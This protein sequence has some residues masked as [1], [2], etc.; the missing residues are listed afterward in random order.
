M[1]ITIVGAGAMGSRFGYML[2]KAGNEVTLVDKWPA[3][4][5]KIRKDGLAVDEEGIKHQVN[6]PIFYP[7]EATGVPDLLILFTKSMGLVG[8]L[9]EVKHLIGEKTKVLCLLNGLGHDETLKKYISPNNIIMGVTLWTAELKGAGSV[10]LTGD[11]SME[12]QSFCEKE[13][14]NA[15]ADVVATLNEAG[16][17]A[18]ISSDVIFSIWR[19]A[20]VNG[21][22]NAN[23][24]I[25]D[26]NINQFGNLRETHTLIRQII[27][28][29]SAVA[30]HYGINL[31]VEK[32]ASGIEAIYGIDQ[33]GLHYPSMHQDLIQHHRLT[34]ID[35]INGYVARKGRELGIPTPFN[36]LI[37]VFVHAKEELLVPKA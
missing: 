5:E 4:I 11:G 33:A 34:E 19:K 30:K 10:L 15:L 3:H 35:Y 13:D 2:D 22:L 25:L 23:C 31:E 6:L 28:E 32:I 8:M 12:I 16:L 17:K 14:T 26:C 27:G 18:H 7:Q 36:E 1:K 21:A 37:T 24:T 9:E 20:C 29:F